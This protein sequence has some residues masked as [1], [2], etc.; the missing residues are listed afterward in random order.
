[1]RLARVP[2]E[3]LARDATLE[4]RADR[5]LPTG[6]VD[7]HQPAPR[8]EGAP[9]SP[10][11]ARP[12]REEGGRVHDQGQVPRA[13]RAGRV[14]TAGPTGGGRRCTRPRG[15]R[16]IRTASTRGSASTA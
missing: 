7:V 16:S 3:G 4:R 14:V 12:A 15:G 11:V 1:A 10:E 9:E 2:K 6:E 8:S 5:G 13:G